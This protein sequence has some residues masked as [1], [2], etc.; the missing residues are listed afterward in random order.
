M[1]KLYTPELTAKIVGEYVSGKSVD[2][3]A[4]E[5]ALSVRSVRAKLVREKVYQSSTAKV[6]TQR[7]TKRENLSKIE[8]LTNLPSKSLDSLVSANSSAISLLLTWIQARQ[9][10]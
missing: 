10:S 4:A 7:T 9:Q 5:N 1:S 8:S 6:A 3:L 2:A